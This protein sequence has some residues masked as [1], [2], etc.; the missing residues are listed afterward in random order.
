MQ[1]GLVV[2]VRR[3]TW[4]CAFLVVSQVV[5]IAWAVN[6][7]GAGRLTL[8]DRQGVERIR[9]E[10]DGPL[11]SLRD[12]QGRERMRLLLLN[13]GPVLHM[14]DEAGQARLALGAEAQ[15]SGLALFDER[16]TLRAELRF[17][18]G[19]SSLQLRDDKQTVRAGLAASIDG[20]GL[21]LRDEGG[22][23][24]AEIVTLKQNLVRAMLS[25]REERAV[26]GLAVD[27]KGKVARVSP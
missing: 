3:L 2:R 9:L 22:A 20:A 11:I 21:F 15:G 17:Q 25:N 6:P 7:R 24:R 4:L 8:C 18:S 14:V 27:G 1:D 5:L 12:P 16:E 26:V 13:E 19:S 10:A 23:L